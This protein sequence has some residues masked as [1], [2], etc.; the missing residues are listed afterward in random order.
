MLVAPGTRACRAGP[1]SRARSRTSK[2][3]WPC[4]ARAAMAPLRGPS[5]PGPGSISM[6]SAAPLTKRAART[7]PFLSHITATCL[8]ANG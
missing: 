8:K 7:W 6:T 3:W 5:S 2:G 1:S 4:R